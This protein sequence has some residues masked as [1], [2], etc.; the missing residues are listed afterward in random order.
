LGPRV[1]LSP[2]FFLRGRDGLQL[3]FLADH[4][5]AAHG[6]TVAVAR[7]DLEDTAASSE[8]N[9]GHVRTDEEGHDLMV[10]PPATGINWLRNGPLHLLDRVIGLEPTIC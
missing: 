3:V 8:T 1:A 9:D 6:D 7:E 4:R 10:G 2:W 5:Q